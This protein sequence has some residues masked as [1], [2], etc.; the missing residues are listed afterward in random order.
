MRFLLSQVR[1]SPDNPDNIHLIFL[2]KEK[3][4]LKNLYLKRQPDCGHIH[5]IYINDYN[6]KIMQFIGVYVDMLT[7]TPISSG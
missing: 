6:N 3:L 1:I 2:N 4:Y 5:I 7:D